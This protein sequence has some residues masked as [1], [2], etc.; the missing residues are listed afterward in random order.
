MNAHRMSVSIEG[1]AAALARLPHVGA[2]RLRLLL[3]H[4]EPAEALAGLGGRTRLHPMVL[5]A[6][7]AGHRRA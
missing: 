1:S 5:R 6:F 7:P 2:S 4:H 3:S